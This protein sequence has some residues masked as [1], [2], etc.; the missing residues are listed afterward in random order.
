MTTFRASHPAV[1]RFPRVPDQRCASVPGIGP[2]W[3][4]WRAGAAPVQPAGSPRSGRPTRP[5]GQCSTD[6]RIWCPIGGDGNCLARQ[7]S[8]GTSTPKRLRVIGCR[9]RRHNISAVAHLIH[10]EGWWGIT[11]P[12]GLRYGCVLAADGNSGLPGNPPREHEFKR[13]ASNLKAEGDRVELSKVIARAISG[14]LPSPVGLP[15]RTKLRWQESNPGHHAQHGRPDLNRRSFGPQPGTTPS[16][17]PTRRWIGSQVGFIAR[18]LAAATRE[19][20]RAAGARPGA[21][22]T[23]P[24]DLFCRP[25]QAPPRLDPHP[26]QQ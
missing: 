6:G 21:L 12:C 5:L 24:G 26:R 23:D 9:N 7:S 11:P 17:R 15:F 2:A 14:R 4:G 19:S 13:R 8:G 3:P 20:G 22:S 18:S 1:D 25:G 16:Q 10:S